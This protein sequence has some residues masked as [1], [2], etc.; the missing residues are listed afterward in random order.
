MNLQKRDNRDSKASFRK[1]TK[2]NFEI[3]D[4][5]FT[6]ILCIL[7]VYFMHLIF[8]LF[9]SSMGK[10]F[11]SKT[12][13]RRLKNKAIIIICHLSYL[14]ECSVTNKIHLYIELLWEVHGTKEDG[15]FRW[16][17]TMSHVFNST[18]IV[19]TIIDIMFTINIFKNI[20]EEI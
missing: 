4:L 14:E 20:Q 9:F 12:K 2:N 6:S 13:V 3:I 1:Q 19:L 15:S 7:C 18:Y 5:Y 16:S 17:K 10:Y 11:E 8:F